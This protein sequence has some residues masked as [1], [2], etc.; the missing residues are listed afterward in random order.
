MALLTGLGSLGL[1]PRPAM[2][3]ERSPSLG[4]CCLPERLP[5]LLPVSQLLPLLHVNCSGGSQPSPLSIHSSP[6]SRGWVEGERGPEGL[7]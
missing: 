1:C 6:W 3:P 2:R 5:E 4:V 7:R